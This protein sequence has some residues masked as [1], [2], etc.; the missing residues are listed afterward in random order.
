MPAA[1]R[2]RAATPDFDLAEVVTEYIR[3]HKSPDPYEIASEVLKQ[4][5]E[6]ELYGVVEMLLPEYVSERLRSYRHSQQK[7][8]RS[9][10]GKEATTSTRWAKTE[11]EDW[12]DIFFTSVS[13]PGE[14]RK[15]LGD[16]TRDDI[17]A[18]SNEY[19][20]AAS[21]NQAKGESYSEIFDAM[22]RR[23]ASIV[24]ELP[25]DLVIEAFAGEEDE[26]DA[27]EAA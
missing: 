21:E 6:D 23:R 16:C 8:K 3:A 15:W 25:A 22:K 13:V 20:D 9:K 17:A 24:S 26:E 27:A 12:D 5:P 7:R 2:R 18:I 1:R 10:K 19:F 4:I 11:H 14:G